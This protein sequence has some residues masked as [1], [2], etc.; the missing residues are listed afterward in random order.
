MI[1]NKKSRKVERLHIQG[2]FFDTLRSSHL[3]WLEETYDP[4]IIRTHSEIIGM[5]V[6]ITEKYEDLLDMCKNDSW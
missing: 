2:D 5:I 3:L 4:E 1:T 6:Q